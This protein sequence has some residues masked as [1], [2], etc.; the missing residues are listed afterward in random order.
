MFISNINDQSLSMEYDTVLS[1]AD[2]NVLFVLFDKHHAQA[3]ST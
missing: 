1:K 2:H 3:P